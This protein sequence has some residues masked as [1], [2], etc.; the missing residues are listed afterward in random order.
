MLKW[1]RSGF[2]PFAAV[3]LRTAKVIELFSMLGYFHV[4]MAYALMVGTIVI[5]R[6]MLGSHLQALYFTLGMI[7]ALH[8]RKTLLDFEREYLRAH[9]ESTLHQEWSMSFDPNIGDKSDLATTVWSQRMHLTPILINLGI[10][11]PTG[12]VVMMAVLNWWSPQSSTHIN[13]GTVVVYKLAAIFVACDAEE[14][15][16]LG[17]IQQICRCY[18]FEAIVRLCILGCSEWLTTGSSVN[19]T[20]KYSL[21]IPF[22]QVLQAPLMVALTAWCWAMASNVYGW[23]SSIWTTTRRVLSTIMALVWTITTSFVIYEVG[24]Q[25]LGSLKLWGSPSPTRHDTRALTRSGWRHAN[26]FLVE[27]AANVVSQT[28]SALESLEKSDILQAMKRRVVKLKSERYRTVGQS[29]KFQADS[30]L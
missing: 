12:A 29:D 23:E 13:L 16:V 15:P 14:K 7:G 2:Y 21:A 1:K 27:G 17:P 30:M 4:F 25:L 6:I 19:S 24:V 8:F 22:Q 26:Q 5:P 9:L 28:T 20:S 10:L 11:V 18:C 3:S